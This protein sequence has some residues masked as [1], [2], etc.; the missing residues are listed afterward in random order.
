[1]ANWYLGVKPQIPDDIA[2][3]ALAVIERLLP[4]LLDAMLA[5]GGR[6]YVVIAPIIDLGLILADCENLRGFPNVFARLKQN[7]RAAF[8]ELFLASSLVKQGYVPALEPSLNG[9]KLDASISIDGEEIYFEVISPIGSE[10]FQH[11]INDGN[12][13][14][15]Q[16]LELFP[17]TSIDIVLLDMLSEKIKPKLIEFI[18]NLRPSFNE[19]SFEELND[20]AVARCMPF[21]PECIPFNLNRSDIKEAKLGIAVGNSNARVIL[22]QRILPDERLQRLM[23]DEAKH[24]SREKI[25]ILMI[26]A[27]GTNPHNFKAWEPLIIRR[28]Q[29]RINRR[30]SAALLFQRELA[31][32]GIVRTNWNLLGNQYAYRTLP[33][34]L[35]TS[36]KKLMDRSD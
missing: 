8:S 20:I 29:P 21:H 5:Q 31:S 32:K 3:E 1:M 10:A 28:F 34:V 15:S 16:L 12:K 7:E 30:F 18:K 14:A 27:S 11:D 23:D 6:G 35:R 36:F 17:E 25:N 33:H 4:E 26:D 24:F 19:N 9:N 22:R 13:F 2:W